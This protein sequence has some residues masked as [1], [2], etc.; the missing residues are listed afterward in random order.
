MR[1]C[2]P[3]LLA[4]L[5]LV[6]ISAQSASAPLI[7]IPRPQRACASTLRMLGPPAVDE[8]RS[9]SR[10]A[11]R[12]AA[13]ARLPRLRGSDAGSG[14]G[15][16]SGHQHDEALLNRTGQLQLQCLWVGPNAPPL[17]RLSDF[18][19][20]E[21]PP[22]AAAAAGNTASANG[23]AGSGPPPALQP[24]QISFMLQVRGT[25][26]PARWSCGWAQWHTCVVGVR[27]AS[28]AQVA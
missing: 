25:T 18:A 5:L 22:G 16:S 3:L 20:V 17:P 15:A 1:L 27:A 28:D 14:S 19:W 23:G 8:L 24:M 11:A 12:D 4:A 21:H 13:A 2:V 6:C 7:G 10:D 9:L 26:G